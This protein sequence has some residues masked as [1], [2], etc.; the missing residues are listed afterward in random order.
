MVIVNC[1][2]KKNE[3]VYLDSLEV[4]QIFREWIRK[5]EDYLQT[6]I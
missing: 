1:L 3:F 5:K 6:V 2:S 4:E